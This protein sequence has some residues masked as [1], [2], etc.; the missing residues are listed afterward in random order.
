[1]KRTKFEAF[2]IVQ[3]FNVANSLSVAFLSNEFL[4]AEKTIFEVTA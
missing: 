1:M 3:Y 2:V 4:S